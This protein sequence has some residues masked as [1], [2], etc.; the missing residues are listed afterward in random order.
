MTLKNKSLSFFTSNT[1]ILSVLYLFF[2]LLNFSNISILVVLISIND[3][4]ISEISL[5]DKSSILEIKFISYISKFFLINV[6]MN[7]LQ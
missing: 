6:L 3:K 5:I 7:L 4:S 1:I 2:I